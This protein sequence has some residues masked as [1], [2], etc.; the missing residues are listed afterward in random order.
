MVFNVFQFVE[1]P[2]VSEVSLTRT[3]KNPP[4]SKAATRNKNAMR[5][6][7]ERKIWLAL[8]GLVYFLFGFGSRCLFLVRFC[9]VL[10]HF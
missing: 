7:A 9:V 5:R 6:Q 2:R 1:E 4:S 10:I 8:L 3:R